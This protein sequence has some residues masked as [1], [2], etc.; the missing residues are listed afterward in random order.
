[1]EQ[2]AATTPLGRA[3]RVPPQA[4]FVASALSRY[5]G[6]SFAVLLFARVDVLGAAWLRIAAAALLFAAWRRPWRAAAALD[7]QGRALIVGLGVVLALMN[8]CFYVAIDR[9]PLATVAAIEFIGPI[10]LA[11]AGARV[12]RNLAAV[13]AAAAGVVLLTGPHLEGEPLGL[14]LAFAN[15]A[16]FA[17]YVVLAHRLAAR[18]AGAGIDRLGGAMLVALVVATPVGA[19]SAG[20]ALADPVVLAAGLGVGVTSSV[21]PYVLDQMALARLPR[22]TYAL[23]VSILPA[24][25]A[26]I[27]VV[28]L[29]Q[30]PSAADVGGIVLVMLG[31][32]LHRPER[33]PPATQNT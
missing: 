30:L 5:L 18:G 28:V 12:P 8:S 29:Q 15:A 26:V 21:V 22:A 17:L 7:R 11:L 19:W 16:L 1:M 4:L 23:F 13:G 3:A 31:V 2:R 24:S 33:P 9:L 32:A 14:A 6:P 25:A 10:A 27:G 20:D